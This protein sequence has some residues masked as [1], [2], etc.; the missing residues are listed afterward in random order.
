MFLRLN[1]DTLQQRA[2][3]GLIPGA[4]IGREWVFLE[5]D[6]I[7]YIR[8]Q[9]P[10]NQQEDSKCRSTSAG[11]R[12]GFRSHGAASELD[13]LLEHQ[14]ESKHKQSTTGLRLICNSD[15]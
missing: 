15:S 14:T 7:A 5:V 2:K 6:L 3:A 11:K 1:P 13:N 12:G 4:K 8:E 9:Y 10:A